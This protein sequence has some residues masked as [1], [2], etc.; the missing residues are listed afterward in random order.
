M[1]SAENFNLDFTPQTEGLKSPIDGATELSSEEYFALDNVINF[2]GWDGEF[3]A[4]NNEID[5]EGWD[6]EFDG[7]YPIKERL[8]DA[9][10][11]VADKAI[12][13]TML[14]LAMYGA[15]QL[16]GDRIGN[17]IPGITDSKTA[18]FTPP[19][20]GNGVSGLEKYY[21]SMY[22]DSIGAESLEKI[23]L[24]DYIN[25]RAGAMESTSYSLV[26]NYNDKTK[27][28]VK[29]Q[30]YFLAMDGVQLMKSYLGWGNV[31]IDE[32]N[33]KVTLPNGRVFDISNST[34]LILLDQITHNIIS[35][36]LA[37]SDL[38]QEY[39]RKA[40]DASWLA[41][42]NIDLKITSETFIFPPNDT[43]IDLSRFLQKTKQLGYP[44]PPDITYDPYS[45]NVNYAG[46]YFHGLLPVLDNEGIELNAA[47]D[48]QTPVHELA[49]HQAQH[50]PNFGQA[51]FNKVVEE[52]MTSIQKSGY[53]LDSNGM[54]VSRYAQ[55]NS[56]EDYAETISSYFVR[57]GQ[58]REDLKR[59]YEK[60][61]I[62]VSR[63]EYLVLA[64][65]YQFARDFFNGDQYTSDGNLFDPKKGDTFS[66]DD[67]SI[68]G[69]AINLRQGP[70]FDSDL[71]TKNTVVNTDRVT[72]IE[73]PVPAIDPDLNIPINFYKV[74][75]RNGIDQKEGWLSDLWFGDKQEQ[76]LSN[77]NNNLDKK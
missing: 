20:R 71:K 11:M 24:A 54:F 28:Y 67:P 16:W 46:V 29:E 27:E 53:R 31:N 4:N 8:K 44:D 66:I 25:A 69:G 60:G 43:L 9:C 14:G 33:K 63:K 1:S 26:A 40:T 77:T 73:G 58:F 34:D 32:S 36:E 35:A 56:S 75:N 2:E 3:E 59:V 17:N 10:Y 41:G 23:I 52:A 6:D 50:N 15:T 61:L 48:S 19:D 12:S 45:E 72:I 70:S 22:G 42:S 49:H 39:L 7:Y 68:D 37:Q 65:K 51:K 76:M 13:L 18:P 5:L 57:G 38:K 55:T 64:A 30:R 21:Q 47:G 62:D 74:I